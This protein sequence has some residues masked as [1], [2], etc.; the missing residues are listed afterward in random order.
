[1][2]V[3]HHLLGHHAYGPPQ[4][5]QPVSGLGILMPLLR[6]YVVTTVVL[7]V[8]PVL[9]PHK[10]TPADPVPVLVDVEIDLGFRQSREVEFYTQD[11]LLR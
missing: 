1:M 8:Q 7:D 5:T 4:L 10:V 9:A 2:N 6:V 3:L 11:G